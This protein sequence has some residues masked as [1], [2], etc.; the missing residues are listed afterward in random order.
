MTRAGGAGKGTSVKQLETNSWLQANIGRCRIWLEANQEF[1]NRTPSLLLQ[2]PPPSPQL[3]LD[4]GSE[5]SSTPLLPYLAT[6]PPWICGLPDAPCR[7]PLAVFWLPYVLLQPLWLSLSPPRNAGN[8]PACFC[9]L[10]EGLHRHATLGFVISK[11]ESRLPPLV[12]LAAS[13][14][15]ATSVSPAATA[16]RIE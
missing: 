14:L 5:H 12:P 16:T 3:Q 1:D 2:T 10:F 4:C 9:P 6:A 13:S 8:R 11:S 7:V 15:L